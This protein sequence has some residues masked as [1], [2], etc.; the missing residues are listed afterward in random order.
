MLFLIATLLTNAYAWT[1]EVTYPGAICQPQT[2]TMASYLEITSGMAV[3]ASTS[4]SL[5]VTCPIPNT[6][7][8]D[9]DV[10]V[11]VYDGS[12]SSKISC[13]LYARSVDTASSCSSGS[14][15]TT[16]SG[17]GA[18]TLV[19][20]ETCGIA[21]SYYHYVECSI[22]KK[23]SSTASPSGIYSVYVRE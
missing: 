15:S 13:T 6:I 3:N 11:Y 8:D 5:T 19:F 9:A 16:S 12:A 10:W 2:S 22:P 17:S 23:S 4:S 18:D 21:D 1:E 20:G 7:D 14:D